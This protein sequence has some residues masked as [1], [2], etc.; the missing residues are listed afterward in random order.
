M[1]RQLAHNC[2]FS[3]NIENMRYFYGEILG[4]KVRF[5]LK[6]RAG[7]DFGYYFECGNSTF[8]E[9]FD[10]VMANEEWGGTND[11]LVHGT[12]F[13]HFCLEVIGL[14]DFRTQILA[15]GWDISVISVGKDFSNQA[16]ISDPDGNLIELM[17]YTGRSAQVAR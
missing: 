12:H 1:V 10:K 8:L 14:D 9:L 13:R 11:R 2:F 6:N 5:T 17:E 15:K 16:W 7:V 4:M 3:D